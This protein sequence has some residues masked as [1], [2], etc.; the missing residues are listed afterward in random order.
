MAAGFTS[1][2][3]MSLRATIGAGTS[4]GISKYGNLFVII[5]ARQGAPCLALIITKRL[6]YLLMPPEV[7]A[8]MVALSDI[9]AALVNPAAKKGSA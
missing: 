9:S 4:G 2:A 5:S 8:P 7:P 6:P 1:A 3:D